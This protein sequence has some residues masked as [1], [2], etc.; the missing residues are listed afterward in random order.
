MKSLSLGI[1]TFLIICLLF[2]SVISAACSDESNVVSATPT[3]NADTIPQKYVTGDI[4]AK[5]LSSTDILY[6]I[7]K[8]DASTNRYERALIF[9]SADGRSYYCKDDKTDFLSAS[10]LE[11]LYPVKV[12]QVSSLSDV[13][14]ITVTSSPQVTTLMSSPTT[15][16]ENTVTTAP[17]QTPITTTL[18]LPTTYSLPSPMIISI[19]DEQTIDS[20]QP[21][22]CQR[23]NRSK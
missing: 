6:L 2:L 10:S 11:K 22:S 12:A 23:R 13:P 1:H 21:R 3:Q 8:Y 17:S 4:V 9:K 20:S 7:V 16:A 18:P 14:I 15:I 19:N 5:S